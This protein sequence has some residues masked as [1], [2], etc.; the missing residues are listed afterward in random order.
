M[1]AF[2][3]TNKG[4]DIIRAQNNHED[5]PNLSCIVDPLILTVNFLPPDGYDFHHSDTF[6]AKTEKEAYDLPYFAVKWLS[7]DNL[8]SKSFVL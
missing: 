3:G 8:L 1:C 7:H 4:L 5:L 2:F 6:P